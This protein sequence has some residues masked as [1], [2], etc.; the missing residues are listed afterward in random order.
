MGPM[1][2][3]DGRGAGGDKGP[4]LPS[5]TLA[6]LHGNEMG[7]VLDHGRISGRVVPPAGEHE[8]VSG[9]HHA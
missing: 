8:V 7:E 9:G 1:I 5:A 2:A 3:H 6:R 4:R